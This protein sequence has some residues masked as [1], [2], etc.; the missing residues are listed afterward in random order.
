MRCQPLG[1]ET[2]TDLPHE[3]GEGRC[4][5]SFDVRFQSIAI[6]AILNIVIV[7]L[8]VMDMETY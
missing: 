2:L 3:A 7:M 6:D 4:Q 5:E 1:F 8:H